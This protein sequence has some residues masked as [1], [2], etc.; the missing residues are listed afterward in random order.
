MNI[1]DY[2]LEVYFDK[3]GVQVRPYIEKVGFNYNTIYRSKDEVIEDFALNGW[4]LVSRG[5]LLLTNTAGN[6]L[7]TFRKELQ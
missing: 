1:I 6:E 5:E 4:T 7:F 2:S 3:F